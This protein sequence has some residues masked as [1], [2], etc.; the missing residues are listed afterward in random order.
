MNYAIRFVFILLHFDEDFLSD[1]NVTES[2]GIAIAS[3]Y[4]ISQCSRLVKVRT[5]RTEASLPKAETKF[6]DYQ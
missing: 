1:S 5:D 3:S 4:T 6:A 2:S